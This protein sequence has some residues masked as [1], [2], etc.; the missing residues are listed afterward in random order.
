MSKIQTLLTDSQHGYALSTFSKIL[1]KLSL[2][3]LI[4]NVL[5]KKECIFRLC[6]KTS[7]TRDCVTRMAEY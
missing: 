5:I 4:K 2:N 7:N 6:L 3:V 1:V